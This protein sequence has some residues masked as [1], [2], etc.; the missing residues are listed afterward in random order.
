VTTTVVLQG[1]GATG[2]GEDVT[3]ESE[4]HDGVPDEPHAG[5]TWSFEDFSHGSTRSRS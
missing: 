1:E 2:Q 4:L 5:G 3:Y